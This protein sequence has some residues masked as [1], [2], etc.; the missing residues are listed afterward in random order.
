MALPISF[1]AQ[2]LADNT[3]KSN[4]EPE[5]TTMRVPIITLTPANVAATE[6]L[7][8]NLATAIAGITLGNVVK[9]D[10]VYVTTE[11]EK[12]PAT[13]KLA[14]RE[15][16]WLLRYH[17]ATSFQ[18]YTVSI[19][20]ADLT[21]LPDHSEFLDLTAG[22]GAALKTAFEAVVRSPADASHS[23]ILDSAQYV[24]RNT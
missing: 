4:G 18:K 13:S 10:I 22:D 24:A 20:T 5:L 1:W 3:V 6:T 12:I 7:T 21:V 9:R 2:S 15:N 17:D 8:G 11:F 23:V 14:Q 19:G 16:K